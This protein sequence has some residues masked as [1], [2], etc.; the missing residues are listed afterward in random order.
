MPLKNGCSTNTRQMETLPVV[1]E[2]GRSERSLS[3]ITDAD[4]V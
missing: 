4:G 1:P 2:N 3:Q